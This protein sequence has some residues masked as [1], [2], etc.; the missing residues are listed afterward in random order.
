MVSHVRFLAGAA[1]LSL[2]LGGCHGGGASGGLMPGGAS[3]ASSGKAAFTVFVPSSSTG[4]SAS[5][6]SLVVTLSQVNGATVAH[7]TSITME[8]SAATHGCT[9]LAGGALSCVATLTAPKGN[10]MFTL[11]MYSGPNGLG[12]QISISQAKALVNAAGT[13]ACVPTSSPSPPAAAI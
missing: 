8:L 7:P 9:A 4:A 13:T 5:P 11:A 2:T 1:F 12:N 10:D 6:Q 3:M